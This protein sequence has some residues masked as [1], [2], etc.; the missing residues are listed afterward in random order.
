MLA[1]TNRNSN[2]EQTAPTCACGHRDYCDNSRNTF[3][4]NHEIAD[5]IGF[6]FDAEDGQWYNRSCQPCTDADAGFVA[7]HTPGVNYG[8]LTSAAM[9]EGWLQASG[10]EDYCTAMMRQADKPA[11]VIVSTAVAAGQHY[12][13]A[14]HA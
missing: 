10:F 12:R 8:D 14:V 2:T 7:F 1:K 6:L 5:K 3:A 9:R 4:G 11:R 13:V